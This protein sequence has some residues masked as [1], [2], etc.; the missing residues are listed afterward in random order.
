MET[1]LPNQPRPSW[2]PSAPEPDVYLEYGLLVYAV[3][4]HL[5]RGPRYGSGCQHRPY[6][7]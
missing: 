2:P 1:M 5:K 4:F 3:A 6:N 7:S